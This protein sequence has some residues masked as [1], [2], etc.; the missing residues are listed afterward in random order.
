MSGAEC[1]SQRPKE[2]F[3]SAFQS[4]LQELFGEVPGGEQHLPYL[5][6]RHPPEPSPQLCRV[7]GADTQG[8][9]PGACAGLLLSLSAQ[10]HCSCR[11][12]AVFPGGL[13]CRCNAAASFF[14]LTNFQLS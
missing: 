10:R 4:S 3:L 5:P 7:S 14:S 6:S 2:W 11:W 13:K 8:L 12:T 1:A 9:L